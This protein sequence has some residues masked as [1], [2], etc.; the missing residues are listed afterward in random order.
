MML[1][2][3]YSVEICRFGFGALVFEVHTSTHAVQANPHGLLKVEVWVDGA[4]RALRV[5]IQP[6]TGWAFCFSISTNI[7]EP[8]NT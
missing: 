1:K 2:G 7:E 5:Q 8:E 3:V 4:R 6:F